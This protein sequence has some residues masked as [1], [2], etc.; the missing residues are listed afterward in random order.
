MAE[1]V[2]WMLNMD[3]AARPGAKTVLKVKIVIIII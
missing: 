3:G 2:S 1:L